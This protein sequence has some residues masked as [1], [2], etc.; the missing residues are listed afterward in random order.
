VPRAEQIPAPSGPIIGR[1][2][3]IDHAV[4]LL[5]AQHARLLTLTGPGG[6]G[7]SR[8][9]VAIAQRLVERMD[10]HVTMVALESVREAGAVPAV[11]ARA[12]GIL[13]K[14]GDS[15][16][17]LIRWL[18][19]ED[20]VLVLDN[21]E[22]IIAATPLLRRILSRCPGVR[23]IVT[24]RI[25]PLHLA[26]EWVIEVGPLDFPPETAE[27]ADVDPTRF[28]AIRYFLQHAPSVSWKESK[29]AVI[30]ICQRL[31]GIPLALELAG[32]RVGLLS[33][34]EIAE[35]TTGWMGLLTRG[36]LDAPERHRTMEQTIDWSYRLLNPSLQRVFRGLG[37]FTGGFSRDAASE[38]TG[39]SPGQLT[40]LLENRLVVVSTGYDH[41]PRFRLLEPVR[42][43][44]SQ[45]AA[46]Q[47]DL[48][49]FQDAFA[50]WAV[51]FVRS[52][53]RSTF[54]PQI[55][56]NDGR[57]LEKMLQEECANLM[58]ALFWTLDQKRIAD[59]LAIAAALT[60]YWYLSIR[61]GEGLPCLTSAIGLAREMGHTENQEYL[62]TVLGYAL[63][64]LLSG[65]EKDALEYSEH[66]LDVAGRLEDLTG[67]GESLG[68]RGYVNLNPGEYER[69]IEDGLRALE[70]F[71]TPEFED[72][73]WQVDLLENLA[74]ASIHHGNVDLAAEYAEEAVTLASAVDASIGYATSLRGLGDVRAHQGRFVE[75]VQAHTDAFAATVQRYGRSSPETWH[76]LS[77]GFAAG[78]VIS[79][80][81]FPD[82]PSLA[83][84][85]VRKTEQICNR[86]GTTKPDN[87]ISY[88]IVRDQ[89]RSS[90]LLGSPT[91]ETR[92]QMNLE[93]SLAE[94]R[95]MSYEIRR[96]L[97][98]D[99]IVYPVLS[100]SSFRIDPDTPNL[101]AASI[102]PVQLATI[103]AIANGKTVKEI[104]AS[105]GV[106]QSSVYS[107]VQAVREKWG[108]PD[109]S[110][111][112]DLA[113]FAVRHGV[114]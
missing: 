20:R 63:L 18:A 29:A 61:P 99:N 13:D 107:R 12:V 49:E 51:R 27:E 25:A 7:K 76:N 110:S 6:I 112:V 55:Y 88:Q 9:A 58:R 59:S 38:V 47:G 57:M 44:A 50:R 102:S 66:A 35:Q 69:S 2:R 74:L 103:R 94:L 34:E 37:V 86:L 89:I 3:Q 32:A 72:Q 17:D 113:V 80:F 45:E 30:R 101:L 79:W 39:A 10:A 42:D 4:N 93:R 43:F 8:L 71:R 19:D 108:L 64:S 26:G 62:K 11:I 24:S 15:E 75:A 114:A 54:A 91:R 14:S 23:I 105:E 56:T 78:A 48:D 21:F 65:A 68:V 85:F 90:G 60:D 92:N 111:L 109:Q 98:P 40:T 31:E 84:E 95:S 46:R 5:V 87:R 36:R 106:H 41:S 70:I 53:N 22:Q 1:D 52:V 82:D 67:I 81:A 97:A 28:P 77:Q 83:V 100:P 104:A 16:A 96:R 33:I 73:P